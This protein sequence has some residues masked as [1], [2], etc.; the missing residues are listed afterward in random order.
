MAGF[1]AYSQLLGLETGGLAVLKY[2]RDRFLRLYPTFIV[3]TAA[4]L[5]VSLCFPVE[6]LGTNPRWGLEKIL[7]EL[8]TPG[9]VLL[10]LPNVAM[11][12]SEIPAWFNLVDGER[13]EVARP[14]YDNSPPDQPSQYIWLMWSKLVP[15]TFALGM[16]LWFFLAA[17]ALVAGGWRCVLGAGVLSYLSWRFFGPLFIYDGYFIWIFWGWAFCVGLAAGDV[18]RRWK[19]PIQAAMNSRKYIKPLV[20]IVL[21]GFVVW[22]L[23]SGVRIPVEVFVLL[24]AATF[25]GLAVGGEG[26]RTDRYLGDLSYP[27]YCSLTIGLFFSEMAAVGGLIAQSDRMHVVIAVGLVFAM[28]TA[29]FIEKPVARF[30]RWI[31]V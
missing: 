10:L 17:P 15:P 12:G 25:P 28:I 1:Y 19:M 26:S 11:F 24:L 16:M 20:M 2:Y 5:A 7:P 30:R 21:C 4:T 23:S 8:E 3:A 27:L 9:K 29:E 6:E 14:I 18:H 22:M 13:L 31:R